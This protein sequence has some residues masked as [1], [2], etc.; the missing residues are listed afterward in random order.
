MKRN[1]NNY[2]LFSQ[3]IVVFVCHVQV[4]DMN[5]PKC[6]NFTR[7]S[8]NVCFF[9]QN[10]SIYKLGETTIKAYVNLLHSLNVSIHSQYT[11]ESFF[12]LCGCLGGMYFILLNVSFNLLITWSLV[13]IPPNKLIVFPPQAYLATGVVWRPNRSPNRPLC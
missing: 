13:P 11:I 5:S 4:C 8:F 10:N 1:S 2:C 6:T 7:S 3:S 12:I 9:N